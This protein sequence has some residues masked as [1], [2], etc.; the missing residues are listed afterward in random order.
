MLTLVKPLLAH[1]WRRKTKRVGKAGI[2]GG[3]GA[4]SNDRC[5]FIILVSSLITINFYTEISCIIHTSNNVLISVILYLIKE[6]V[7]NAK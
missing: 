6:N 7:Q 4:D 1:I 5:F 2:Q 3:D